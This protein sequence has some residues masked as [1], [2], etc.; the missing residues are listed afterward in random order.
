MADAEKEIGKNCGACKKALKRQ[1]RYYRDNNYYCN[2]N[3]YK[4][5]VD[6]QAKTDAE[7]AG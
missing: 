5:F 3:C 4:N 6:A 1:K 7:A 2:K